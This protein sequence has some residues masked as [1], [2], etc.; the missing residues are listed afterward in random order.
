MLQLHCLKTQLLFFQYQTTPSEV[1]RGK[2]RTPEKVFHATAG[3]INI[4][5][6]KTN[7]TTHIGFDIKLRSQFL[8]ELPNGH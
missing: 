2:I 7:F 6:N 3:P 1:F 4:T 5:K 8:K